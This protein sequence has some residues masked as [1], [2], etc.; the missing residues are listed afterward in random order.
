MPFPKG[1]NLDEPF[2]T[3]TNPVTLEITPREFLVRKTPSPE[4]VQQ[5]WTE[6]CEQM[7]NVD[8]RGDTY[9]NDRVMRSKHYHGLK[10][11]S[12]IDVKA[13]MPLSRRLRECD[14]FAVNKTREEAIDEMRGLEWNIKM[15]QRPHS[16]EP[17]REGYKTPLEDADD[18]GEGRKRENVIRVSVMSVN[19]RGGSQYAQPQDDDPYRETLRNEVLSYNNPARYGID[20]AEYGIS[21]INRVRQKLSDITSSAPPRAPPNS[22]PMSEVHL[23]YRRDPRLLDGLAGSISMGIV[24]EYERKKGIGRTRDN[25]PTTPAPSISTPGRQ[26][27]VVK[28]KDPIPARQND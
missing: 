7:V 21:T 23:N 25:D 12:D 28:T 1:I 14:G 6:K 10:H 27:T 22:K 8:R 18:E 2:P 9:K 15:P 19:N 16:P 26:R 4:A 11:W 17:T 24:N 20:T 13:L 3:V 5:E